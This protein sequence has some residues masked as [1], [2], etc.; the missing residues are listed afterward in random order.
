LL[1]SDGGLI[2]NH[3]GREVM[4]GCWFRSTTKNVSGKGAENPC[5]GAKVHHFRS[6]IAIP[7]PKL[8]NLASGEPV[9]CLT[10]PLWRATL[11]PGPRIGIYPSQ[12]IDSAR[13]SANFQELGGLSSCP[14]RLPGCFCPRRWKV[15]GFGTLLRTPNEP[16]R[17]EDRVSLRKRSLGFVGS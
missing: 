7:A 13:C 17:W 16:S 12:P 6:R 10:F 5:T 8:V 2:R 14:V 3:S 11:R 15:W 9:K 4:S 1:L